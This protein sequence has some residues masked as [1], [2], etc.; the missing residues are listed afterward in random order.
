MSKSLQIS[1]PKTGRFFPLRRIILPIAIAIGLF[2]FSPPALA[3]TDIQIA[4]IAYKDCG[5]ELSEGIVASGD[6]S[7]ANCFIISGTAKNTSGKPVYDADVFGVIYD[8]NGNNIMPNRTRIGNI[9][10][11]PPGNS[12]FEFRISVPANLPTPFKLDKFKARGFSGQVKPLLYENSLDS[13]D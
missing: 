4:N 9:Q 8:A 5:E 1:L 2:W 10:S 13:L 12:D 11:V 7:A 6:M 3:L